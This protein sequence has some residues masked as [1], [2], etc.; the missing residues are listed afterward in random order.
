MK[1]KVTKPNTNSDVF[2]MILTCAL[3]YLSESLCCLLTAHSIKDPGTLHNS[4][5]LHTHPQFTA[6]LDFYTHHL[7]DVCVGVFMLHGFYSSSVR[8]MKPHLYMH[9]HIKRSLA[10]VMDMMRLKKSIFCKQRL[11]YFF[12]ANTYSVSAQSMLSHTWVPHL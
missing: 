3:V 11:I 8:H 5:Q 1:C 9:K 7:P 6:V 2:E 4:I 10:S 12:F